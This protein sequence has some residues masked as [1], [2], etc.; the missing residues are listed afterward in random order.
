MQARLILRSTIALK[1]L[2]ALTGLFMVIFLIGHLMGNLE[3][4]AGPKATNDY[5]AMLK[6]FPKALW[7]FRIA[8][9]AAVIIHII[10]TI[11]LSR[12]NLNAR[13]QSYALK[14]SRKASLNSRTMMLSG[15]TI[16]A[17][18]AYHLAHYTLG[19]TNPEYMLLHDNLGRHHV[20]N[21]VIMGFSNAWISAF[22][23]IAQALL[24]FHI[25]HGIS[26]AARTLGISDAR[27]FELIKRGGQIFAAFVALLFISIPCAVLLGVLTLEV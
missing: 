15:I 21:M 20:Y 18:V 10:T 13:S 2:V 3:V 4:Y 19:I 5:A 12:R 11:V 22:Y 17:F 9:I 1:F 26:S 7:G 8:L 27:R 6:S 16:F 23:I 14:K 25:S 24:G